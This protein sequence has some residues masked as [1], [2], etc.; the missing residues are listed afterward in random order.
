MKW[1]QKWWSLYSVLVLEELP[2][3]LRAHRRDARASVGGWG[4]L[5]IRNNQPLLSIR[6][7]VHK[8]LRLLLSLVHLLI[9]LSHLGL[10]NRHRLL[11]CRTALNN[12]M[13]WSWWWWYTP[14]C[15]EGSL[16]L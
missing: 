16:S 1:K 3:G 2:I 8:L 12:T 10:L 15:E 5:C 4:V 9:S 13:S 11:S 14:S 6:L 7:S